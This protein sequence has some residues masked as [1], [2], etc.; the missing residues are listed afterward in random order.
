VA[1]YERAQGCHGHGTGDNLMHEYHNYSSFKRKGQ[2]RVRG[3]GAG[4]VVPAPSL[5]ACQRFEKKS[6]AAVM[7]KTFCFSHK[8]FVV[9]LLSRPEGVWLREALFFCFFSFP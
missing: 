9:S 6:G 3:T 8:S 4:P 5:T 7:C 1:L 2:G